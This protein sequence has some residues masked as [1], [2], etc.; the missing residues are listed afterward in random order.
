MKR[1]L[2]LV[3]LTFGIASCGGSTTTATTS[4]GAANASVTPSASVA[5]P[6]V[7]IDLSG[8]GFEVHQEPG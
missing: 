8:L 2:W 3:V 1:L 5:S 7:G 6:V 4:A